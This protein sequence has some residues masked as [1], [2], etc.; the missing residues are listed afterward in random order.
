[1][2][3]GKKSEVLPSNKVAVDLQD[4]TLQYKPTKKEYLNVIEYIADTITLQKN[5]TMNISIILKFEDK[6]KNPA[7]LIQVNVKIGSSSTSLIGDLFGNVM[8]KNVIS[9]ESIEIA[10]VDDRF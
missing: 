2:R 10:T 4:S 8:L 7:V 1:M 9:T 5:G 6:Y 3:Y